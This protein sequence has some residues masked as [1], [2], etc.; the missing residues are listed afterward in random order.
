MVMLDRDNNLK[1]CLAEDLRW[2]DERTIE[3][4]LRKA[5]F[6]NGEEF[7]R[8]GSEVELGSL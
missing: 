1:P 6:H 7:Q 3:F 2:I 8:G 5:T 4:K